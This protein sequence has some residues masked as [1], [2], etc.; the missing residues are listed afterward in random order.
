MFE[1]KDKLKILDDGKW[2]SDQIKLR[3][4]KDYLYYD[5]SLIKTPRISSHALVDLL[6]F[7]KYAS[8]GK[9]LLN[10]FGLIKKSEI[11]PYQEYK[12]GI[13][14]VFAK[15]YLQKKYG[16]QV[17]VE[18]FT[19]SQF[20]NFNQFPEEEPFSGVLD[21]MLHFKN[22]SKMTV[23][24]KSKEMR[25]YE[26][27]AQMQIYPKEQMVQGA[28][29]AILA[30][31]ERYM[32]LWIFISPALSKLL[33]KLAEKHKVYKT[34]LDET[35]VEK[36]FELEEDLWIWGKDFDKAVEDLEITENDMLFHAKE[37]DVDPRMVKAY[38]EKALQLY[39]E[40]YMNRRIDKKLF[41]RDE[42][43]M[44]KSTLLNRK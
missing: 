14:E 41:Q 36:T 4:D 15:R 5:S 38:R 27:I 8:P 23:E 2:K 25:E 37:F 44:L 43:N 26:K 39:N 33:K 13:A 17:D 16:S 20:T 3:L 29:Q 35:G 12:G 7:N 6:G 32:M 9:T 10:M 28:N 1:L 21:L 19:V 31:T 40:F 22:S 18:S 42:L 30:K 11:D 34:I 24:V